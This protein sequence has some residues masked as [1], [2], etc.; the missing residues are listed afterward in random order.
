M[1]TPAPASAGGF[2]SGWVDRY[3]RN[4]LTPDEE[5]AFEAALFDSAALRSD[6]ISRP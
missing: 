5:M 1:N 2:D 3:V 4:Q 6:V